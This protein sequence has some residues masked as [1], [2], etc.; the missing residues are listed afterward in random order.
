[1]IQ[2]SKLPESFSIAGKAKIE[3]Q[4]AEDGDEK[5]LRRFSMV[6]YTGG[7]MRLAGFYHPVVIDLTGMKVTA[8]SRP[9]L[10]EHDP[11]RIVGH[12]ENIVI[13]S[14][15]VRVEGTISAANEH[16][17]EVIE[18]ADNGFPWQVSVGANSEKLAFVD[19]G[20]TVQVNGR[21]FTGPVYVARQSRLGEVSFVAMGADDRTSAKMVAKHRKESEMGFEAWLQAKGFELSELSEAQE[22]SLRAM[23]TA[24]DSAEPDTDDRDSGDTRTVQAS[25]TGGDGA[26]TGGDL[27]SYQKQLRAAAAKE[28]HRFTQIRLLCQKYPDVNTI[29]VD[30]A[31]VSIEA[32][33]IEND[34]S[35]DKLEL[36]LMRASRPKAPAGHVHDK[37]ADAEAI[38][39]ALLCSHGLTEE[40]VG[41]WYSE[42]VMNAAVSR[43]YRSF[44]LHSLM[45]A[46]IR[47]AGQHYSGSFKSNDFI[48]A[49]YTAERQLK[50]SGFSTLTVSNILENVANKTLIASYEAQETTWQKI[51]RT[52]NMSDF[53][54]H[55]RYRLDT[56][57]AFRKVG[58]DGELKHIGMTDSKYTN[59]LDTFGAIVSLTRQDQINDDLDA[60]L[61]I[62]TAMGRLAAV[63]IEGAVYVL[64]LSNPG[65]FFG[66]GNKN[67]ITGADTALSGTSLTKMKTQF[68]N[69]VDANNNPILVSPKYLLVGTTLEDTADVLLTERDLIDGTSTTEKPKK[70]PHVGTLEKVKSP[71]LNN[72]SI[73]DEDG[74]AISGQSDTQHY[75][76]ADPSV[77]AAMCVGFLN[78]QRRPTIESGETSF[79]TLGM[80]WRGYHDF[81]VGMEDPVAAVKS[82][83][84]A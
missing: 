54:V 10:R 9:V 73:K 50:A 4:A 80:Q 19:S 78:G 38:E 52:S 12:T 67:Y 43:N 72:T 25:A 8:K 35:V 26:S 83:G 23:Y 18:S 2:A 16:S 75:I 13:G 70:N 41:K 71:Y 69:M 84:A 48:R 82:K 21:N 27:E 59:Q 68:S 24:E 22:A 79:D 33:A 49:T 29:N 14:R 3:I 6:A 31:D 46:V 47:A 53:K 64:L 7:A 58:A 20:E 57:G 34:W 42:K 65:S 63:R 45:G 11:S 56:T 44:T 5:K 32:H 61:V 62:P 15:D 30:G 17:R 39:A 28:S 77:R 66:T 51:C 40:Q 81:G 74:K 37:A 60:F 36:H 76:F 55:S 1:M